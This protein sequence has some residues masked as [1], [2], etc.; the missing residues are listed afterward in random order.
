M[1]MDKVLSLLGLARRAGKMTLGFDAVCSSAAKKESK[2]I[3][4]AADV[5]EGTMR[6]L[7]NHLSGNEIDIREMPYGME[8]INAAIG[9]PVRL[10]SINDSGFA[11]RLNQL[12][13]N[14]NGEE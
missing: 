6:K 11:E 5:S 3:L 10:I 12:L 4:A 13:D 8:A 2:L 14:G 1:T 9:K 7:T